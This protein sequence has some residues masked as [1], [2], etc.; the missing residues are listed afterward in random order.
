MEY[1]FVEIINPQSTYTII[2]SVYQHPS[3]DAD[4]F[5]EYKLRPF[6]QK[7]SKY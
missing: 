6:M 2:W 4:E 5:N 1:V 7:L 3:F